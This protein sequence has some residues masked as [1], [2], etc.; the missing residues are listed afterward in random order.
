MREIIAG[1]VKVAVN[2]GNV[3]QYFRENGREILGSVKELAETFV[4]YVP[5]LS[6]SG[7]PVSNIEAYLM[8]GLK[9]I[10]PELGTAYDDLWQ[11]VD[12]SDLQGLTGGTLESRVGRVLRERSISKDSN[13]AEKLAQ[14]YE[15]GY[16]SAVPGKIPTSVT[17]N[18][19]AQELNAAMQN[20]Y[21]T[22]WS[23]IVKG[24]LDDLVR[25][26]D[27]VNAEPEVQ[28]KMVSYLYDYAGEMAKA[29]LFEEYE[30][31]TRDD[32]IDAFADVG[33]S[34]SDF[35]IAYGKYNEIYNMDISNGEK[36]DML[37]HW[38]DKQGYSDAETETIRN[39]LVYYNMAPA[40][41]SKYN[42]MVD[43]G[44]NPELAYKVQKEMYKLDAADA[45]DVEYWRLAVDS[46]DNEAVQLSLLA[47][48]M[49]D[50]AFQK[51]KMVVD[52]DVSPDM[53]VTYY[54]TRSKY[55]ADGNGAYTQAEIKAVI[56]A[57]GSRWTNEQKG[58]LW[59]MATGSTSTKNNPYSKSAGQK[60]LDAKAAAKE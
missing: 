54:E 21:S 20:R 18:G 15:A 14:L 39:E 27:F 52:L 5:G 26:D 33:L 28:A 44:A 56:D 45:A 60:W 8:G 17:V 59:Q 51:L 25:S 22:A 50:A 37:S 34:L 12:K 41:A 57:M 36:A 53:Y 46:S 30:P 29:E 3:G 32:S 4:M 49:S 58:V 7:V 16:K 2:G 9:W 24:T 11:N 40:A 55:D 6:T 48:R 10:S 31:N 47:G 38:V 43:N 42:K 19:E 13:T 23:E 35:L 1:A